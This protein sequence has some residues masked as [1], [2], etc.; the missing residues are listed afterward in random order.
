MTNNAYICELDINFDIEYLLNLI[1]NYK[2]DTT[3]LKHQR[4]VSA[5]EYL[6]SL[7]N[8]FQILS[9]VWNFYDFEPNRILN[10]HID[11]ERSCALNIPLRG[12]NQSSTIFYNLPN[13]A[14][15]EYDDTR[16]LNWIDGCTESDKVFEFTLTRPTLIKNSIPH[17]VTNGPV[18]RTIMSWSITK[19]ITFEEATDFFKNAM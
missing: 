12:T 15:L 5:D 1:S 11:S 13:N 2:K 19:D 18:R 6:T 14:N 16:K 3:L 9:P 17:S 7:K 4:L 8:K 10:C